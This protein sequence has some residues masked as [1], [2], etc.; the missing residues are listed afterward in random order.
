MTDADI[1]N[2][3][4]TLRTNKLRAAELISEVSQS[5]AESIAASYRVY[6]LGPD[7]KNLLMWAHYGDSHKGI[8]LEFSLRNAI[9]CTALRCE[10][11]D[12]F[13]LVDVHSND[14]ED[15]MRVLLAKG[16]PWEYEKEYRLVAQ[17]RNQA[18]TQD[19]L[20]TDGDNLKLPDGA[21]TAVIVG[22]QGDFDQVQAL[23]S[24]VAPAIAVKRAVRVPNRYQI[25][26]VGYRPR[27]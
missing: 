4:T 25:E 14:V 19:A 18:V 26:I 13:P 8:C 27:L 17:E 20:L 10:Y 24:R 7:V 23:V 5:V 6:C 22:C 3:E 11:L 12:E 1:A 16:R 9:M 2:M 15:Q 21:L